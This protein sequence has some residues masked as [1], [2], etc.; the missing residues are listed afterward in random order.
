MTDAAKTKKKTMH[1]GRYPGRALCQAQGSKLETS[2]D[3][4]EVNC[5]RCAKI[6][7]VEAQ[8]NPVF[9]VMVDFGQNL[10][11]FGD[12]YRTEETL[13]GEAMMHLLAFMDMVQGNGFH[14]FHVDMVAHAEL[15]GF[16]SPD[17][18]RPDDATEDIGNATVRSA[19]LIA[20]TLEFD[21]RDNV[22]ILVTAYGPVLRIRFYVTGDVDVNYPPIAAIEEAE[23]VEGDEAFSYYV[24]RCADCESEPM[25]VPFGNVGD[26]AAWAQGHLEANPDHKLSFGRSTK[27]GE[28]EEES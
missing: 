2:R 12:T 3:P 8:P 17:P 19:S 25:D 13:D 5:T 23:P 9:P 21:E 15:L 6:D 18:E 10:G 28:F 16:R 4:D 11:S 26:R 20:T 1:L 7:P 24:V 14:V 27:L 22:R